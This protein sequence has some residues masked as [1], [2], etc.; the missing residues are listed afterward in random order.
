MTFSRSG[1]V[2][3]GLK[4]LG[5]PITVDEFRTGYSSFWYLQ[6][7][8]PAANRLLRVRYA[9]PS[10]MNGARREG[11]RD[12]VH[13]RHRLSNFTARRRALTRGA[14]RHQS[15]LPGITTD[16]EVG[17]PRRLARA[18]N[19]TRACWSTGGRTWRGAAQRFYPLSSHSGLQRQFTSPVRGD[20]MAVRSHKGVDG[21]RRGGKISDCIQRG[22]RIA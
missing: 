12:C 2:L 16:R 21:G 7:C 13:S 20:K 4:S 8:P 18:T 5:A 22:Q 6:S 17:T 11:D 1:S 19:R 9:R 14:P 10:T 15:G 3:R